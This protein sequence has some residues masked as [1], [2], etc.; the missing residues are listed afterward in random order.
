MRCDSCQKFVSYDTDVEPE[1]VSEP[2]VDGNEV[3]FEI[4]RVLGCS[5]CS[6]ELKEATLEITVDLPDECECKPEEVEEGEDEQPPEPQWEVEEGSLEVSNTERAQTH[7]RHGK[8][9]KRSRYQRYY[10]GVEGGGSVKCAGCGM[11]HNYTFAD[12]VQA[13]GMEELV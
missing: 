12:E 11:E 5:E 8:P 10:Y 2:Q 13:S 1:V 3:T 7:D 6:Q 9:I 4:R